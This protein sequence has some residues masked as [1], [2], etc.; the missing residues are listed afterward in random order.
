MIFYLKILWIVVSILVGYNLILPI[1]LFL[2]YKLIPRKH[3]S[4]HK[5]EEPDFA[6]IVTA[7]EQTN[8]LHAAVTSLLN[9]NYSN[10][11]IYIVA[12]KCDISNL[13]YNNEKVVLLRPEEPLQSN[14]RSHFYA[15][16]RFKRDHQFLTIIDSD[17]L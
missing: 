16:N 4:Y 1:L 5:K 17:T 12:D 8:T 14:T 7:Y 6:I 10:Y 11:I 13:N 15:I 2:I 3:F 9:L